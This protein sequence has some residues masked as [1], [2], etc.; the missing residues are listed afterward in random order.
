MAN[1]N[2]ELVRKGYEAFGSFRSGDQAA[3]DDFWA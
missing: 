2:E 3:V 1:A